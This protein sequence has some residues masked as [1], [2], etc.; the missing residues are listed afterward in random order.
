MTHV[1]FTLTILYILYINN[2][3]L[4]LLVIKDLKSQNIFINIT[5]K[6]EQ[7][8]KDTEQIDQVFHDE[9]LISCGSWAG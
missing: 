9:K 3:F 2:H 5:T 7:F 8:L 6:L 4:F 1:S